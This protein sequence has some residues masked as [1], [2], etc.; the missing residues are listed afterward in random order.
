MLISL[1]FLIKMGEFIGAGIISSLVLQI[2]NHHDCFHLKQL[3]ASVHCILLFLV[4]LVAAYFEQWILRRVLHR[5]S[6]MIS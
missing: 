3:Y 5:S 2:Y 4:V 1:S 6:N